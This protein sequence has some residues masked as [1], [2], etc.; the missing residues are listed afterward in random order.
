MENK[1]NEAEMLRLY[2]DF[3]KDLCT[4][5]QELTN[6]LTEIIKEDRQKVDISTFLE[7]VHNARSPIGGKP[8]DV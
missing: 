2:L 5:Y 6:S 1:N 4:K 3:Y 8:L 7:Q